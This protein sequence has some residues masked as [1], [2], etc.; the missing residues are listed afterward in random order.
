MLCMIWLWQLQ[1]KQ[2][3]KRGLYIYL[4]YIIYREVTS[5]RLRFFFLR[6][7]EIYKPKCTD[8]PGLHTA[9]MYTL[10]QCT[11]Y[12]SAHNATL[13]QCT[14]CLSVYTTPSVHTVPGYKRSQCTHC[15][16]VHTAQG[17]TL[18]KCTGSYEAFWLW[19][20]CL[21]WVVWYWCEFHEFLEAFEV[22]PSSV[23]IQVCANAN[24]VS[25]SEAK[26]LIVFWCHSHEV[27]LMWC[28]LRAPCVNDA[29]C[30][31]RCV[32]I[33]TVF[34]SPP[35]SVSQPYRVLNELVA[36]MCDVRHLV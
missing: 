27:R 36:P 2:M 12:P 16:S 3:D 28:E 25:G 23:L 31:E 33:H 19:V 20:F 6:Y 35:K 34:P 14:H 5:A 1:H 21:L 17:Y 10:P 11:N 7:C 22:Q 26:S 30:E 8:C 29:R 24:D 9:P 18:P 32:M 15:P 13:N 4:T